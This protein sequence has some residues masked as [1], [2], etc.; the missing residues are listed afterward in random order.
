[1]SF[2]ALLRA[3]A[4]H[5]NMT[6]IRAIKGTS[7]QIV[8]VL[9]SLSELQQAMRM[10]RLPDLFEV[11]LDALCPHLP[12]LEQILPRLSA[13][14][15]ITARHPAEGGLNN[16]SAF[17]RGELLR[18]FLPA[19]AC[20]DVEL[21]SAPQLRTI[22]AAAGEHKIR[23]IISVHDLRRTL[24][25]NRLDEWAR[26]AESL[27]ADVFKIVTRTETAEELAKFVDFFQRT[28][29]RMEVS[30]MGA[31]KFGRASRIYF[32]THGSALNYVHLGNPR[33]EGQLSLRQMS[34]YMPRLPQVSER[35]H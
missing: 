6:A 28:R 12:A 35:I 33:L 16:L 26:D 9:S 18:R 10:R 3:G 5:Y 25:A 17:R 34:R 1:M 29:S 22:L 2:G 24:V 30:A 31:G 21:R 15:V 27:E 14:L 23:R 8:A 19:A 11:R 20:V 4:N 13:P 7:P 32:A